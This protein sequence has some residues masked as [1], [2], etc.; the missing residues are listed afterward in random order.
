MRAGQGMVYLYTGI[1]RW[2]DR[3]VPLVM[4]IIIWHIIIWD[5]R[6]QAH[7]TTLGHRRAP[8]VGVVSPWTASRQVGNGSGG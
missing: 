2:N 7:F 6:C 8:A 4:S 5:R 3:A 1:I